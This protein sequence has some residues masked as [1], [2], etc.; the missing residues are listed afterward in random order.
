METTQLRPSRTPIVS[1]TPDTSTP[2]STQVNTHNSAD[3]AAFLTHFEGPLTYQTFDDDK[4]DDHVK[5]P[6]LS[7]I[8][9]NPTTEQ[10]IAL[11]RR[12]AGIYLMVNEGDGKG[13]DRENVTRIRAFC[14]DFDGAAL[15]ETWPLEP[16][17]IVETSIGKY[18]A[19]WFLADGNDVLLKNDDW[20]A[21]Q[22]TI[23]RM[24][25]SKEIDCTGLNRVMRV[26]GFLHLKNPKTPF[27]SRI[28]TATGNRYDL[29]DITAAFP[30]PEAKT[31]PKSTPNRPATTSTT[32]AL[33]TGRA[34]V[35][36]KYALKVM[37]EECANLAA[38][39]EGNRNNVL[40]GTAYRVG[41]LVGGGHLD[42]DEAQ[43]ALLDA[44]RTAGLPDHRITAT[45]D[46]GFYGGVGEPDYLD[47]VGTRTRPGAPVVTPATEQRL[48]IED[49]QDDGETP[50]TVQDVLAV[51]PDKPQ[52]GDYRDLVLAQMR[53]N[54]D[55]YRYHQT[56]RSWWRYENGVY[57]EVT[58]EKMGQTVDRILQDH[59]HIVKNT[60]ITEVMI[61]ISRETRVGSAT[62]D[63]GAWELNAKNGILN[64]Q[65]G[66]FRPHTPDYFSTIQSAASYD[67][68]K[69]PRQW[70]KFLSEAVPDKKERELLQMFSGYSA[71]GDTSAQKA[72][73]VVGDG[74]T[75]KGVYTRTVS[76]VL[77]GLATSA[78]IE[79]IKD[80]SFGLSELVGKRMCV[81]SEMPKYVDWLPFKRITGEDKI[82]VDVKYKNAYTTKLDIKLIILSNVL[83]LLG[84]DTENSSLTRRFLPISFNVTPKKRDPQLENRLTTPDELSGILN[85]MLEGLKLLQKRKMQFPESTNTLSREIV[86]ASNPVVRFLVDCCAYDADTAISTPASEVYGAYQQWC[87]DNNIRPVNGNRFPGMLLAAGRF[88]SKSIEKQRKNTGMQYQHL[89]IAAGN[90]DSW[91]M[92]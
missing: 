6:A 43:R 34:G 16:S 87:T 26:P 73:F 4:T 69:K 65:T 18:H 14:A 40:N 15:P 44:A 7:K 1:G 2:T 54:G 79:N 25:G 67:P 37:Q 75:G 82:T 74:G 81:V 23:A 62:T 41:R 51:M 29:A 60:M 78:A 21:Q 39:P 66:N 27:L 91:H 24:V 19:Y 38:T 50:P 55:H 92:F 45:L 70:L 17:L 9:H 53:E 56:W 11:S 8:L 32:A 64:M 71:T 57:V 61:K 28:L 49:D 63:Q 85:W 59:G 47:H 58:D 83:P 48:I 68:T 52:L 46:S 76:K 33:L 35:Q 3:F 72:L 12:G 36:R 5:N 30:A 84:E 10:L 42:V 77:G 88:Y 80:G 20:N 22:K 90:A 86:E 31:E 13:R 89:K